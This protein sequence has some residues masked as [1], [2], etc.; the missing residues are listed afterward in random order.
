[1]TEKRV[2]LARDFSMDPG[3]RYKRQGPYSGELFREQIVKWLKAAQ[4]LHIDLD[5]TTGIGSSFLDEAFGGLVR[6]E[7]MSPDDVRRRI[8]IKSERDETYL[9]DIEES[10][11]QAA[12]QRV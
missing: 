11:Q 2:S 3:P 5:G 10:L 7:G 9:L 6:D 8:T 4:H 1:M 12:S